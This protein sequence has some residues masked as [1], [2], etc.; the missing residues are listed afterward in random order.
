MIFFTYL[1]R[2][3]GSV[4]WKPHSSTTPKEDQK[5]HRL[6]H[7]EYNNKHEYNSL[8]TLKDEKKKVYKYAIFQLK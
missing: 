2:I 3:K 5:A 6:K 4:P 7:C 8:N 1:T